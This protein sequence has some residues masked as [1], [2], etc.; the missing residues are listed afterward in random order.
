M[1]AVLIRADA[2][3]LKLECDIARL[4]R[5][6][7]GRDL[8]GLQRQ[9]QDRAHAVGIDKLLD[10]YRCFGSRKSR[11]LNSRTIC[12]EADPCSNNKYLPPM[13]PLRIHRDVEAK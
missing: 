4:T 5:S 12:S 7:N 1:V 6:F 8:A 9:N 10:E 3:R 2:D 11:L 13:I